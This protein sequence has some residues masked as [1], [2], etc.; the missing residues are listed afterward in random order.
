MTGTGAA[1]RE[2]SKPLEYADCVNA[3]GIMESRNE[4]DICHIRINATMDGRINGTEG[5]LESMASCYEKMQID[6]YSGCLAWFACAT[7]KENDF[8]RGFC[9]RRLR[10][11]FDA[12]LFV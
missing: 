6:I 1:F 7:T 4:E 12:R 2:D 10:A 5:R 9:A 11:F 8:A 3:E